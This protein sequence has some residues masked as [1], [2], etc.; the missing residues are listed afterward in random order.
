MTRPERP[1][2]ERTGD[3]RLAAL[4]RKL[5]QLCGAPPGGPYPFTVLRQL[6]TLFALQEHGS[7][8]RLIRFGPDDEEPLVLA[9]SCLVLPALADAAARCVKLDDEAAARG[10]TDEVRR[11]IDRVAAALAAMRPQ[12][13][14]SASVA[15]THPPGEPADQDADGDAGAP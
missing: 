9:L 13:V 12:P 15:T 11:A 5:E 4:T 1:T 7:V 2:P 8:L 10:R 6:D 14:V 3:D